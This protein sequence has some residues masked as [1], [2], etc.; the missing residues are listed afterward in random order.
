[1][2]ECGLSILNPCICGKSVDVG[3][4]KK[5]DIF[6]HSS[7]GTDL[8]DALVLLNGRTYVFLDNCLSACY[9]FPVKKGGS[10]V[11]FPLDE[12]AAGERA[13]RGR[14]DGRRLSFGLFD[15][16]SVGSTQDWRK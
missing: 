11:D 12:A 15:C 13:R 3:K 2:C 7:F 10:L 5:K 14:R 4:K 6:S 16:D 9:R 8:R 1:M